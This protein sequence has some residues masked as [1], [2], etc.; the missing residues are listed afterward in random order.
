M[1]ELPG[2]H[3]CHLR[4]LILCITWVATGCPDKIL[5][6]D[7]S[8]NVFLGE[9]SIWIGGLCEFISLPVDEWVSS[10]PLK[11]KENKKPSLLASLL[12]P[13]HLISFHLFCSWTGIYTTGSPGSQAFECG[14]NCTTGFPGSPAC[15]WQIR[16]LLSLHNCMSQFLKICLMYVINSVSLENPDQYSSFPLPLG[17]D[18]EAPQNSEYYVEHHFNP[19]IKQA[20]KSAY[21]HSE[22]CFW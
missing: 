4:W 2:I 17:A 7:V 19:L 18:T 21:G 13:G 15:R 14:L 6:L 20:S 1:G 9:I 12:E 22:F 10:S 3:H 8:V 5:F 16:W 11:S